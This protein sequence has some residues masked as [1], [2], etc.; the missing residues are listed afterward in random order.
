MG[1]YSI[2]L[3][4]EQDSRSSYR[5]LIIKLSKKLKTP[6]FDPHCTLY[7]RLD[8]NIDQ[9]MPTVIEL[10]KTNNQF[11][12]NVKRIKTGKTKWKSLYLA[13]DNNEEMK[14]LYGECKKKFGS[15]RKYSFD[16]HLS[17]AYGIFDP[18]SIHYATKNIIIPEYLAFSAIAIVKTGE[19]IEDW[20]IV[21]QRQFEGG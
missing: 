9:I 20:E 5:D 7:G 4:L 10:V 8:L 13:L 2:W 14:Y 11:S 6:S 16:P 21:F 15:L 18:E 12:T 3:I 1:V 17:I 19:N